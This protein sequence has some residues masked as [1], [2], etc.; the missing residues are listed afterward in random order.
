MRGFG[1]TRGRFGV[2]RPRPARLRPPSASAA[3][4]GR[5][6]A[7]RLRE[8]GLDLGDLAFQ[9]RDALAVLARGCSSWLRRAVRSASAPVS[10]PKVF[11]AAASAA[12]GLGDARRRRRQRR[13]APARARLRSVSSSV[14]KRASAASAS[15]ASCARA[16]CPPRTARAAGRAR[17]CARWR[18]FPRA[19][20]VSRAIRRRCSAAAALAS[21]SRSGGSSGGGFAWRVAASRLRAGASATRAHAQI[22]GA[23]GFRDFGVGARPSADDNSV[24]SALRTSAETCG[25]APP[26]APG[27]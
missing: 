27:A 16:R 2:A 20:S 11:S 19:S 14:R 22:L 5:L 4:S 7:A 26:G 6:S 13:S 18:A 9:P 8:L 15:A 25:S 23:L 1:A 21:S 12:V 10:S 3:R 24:A 17:R